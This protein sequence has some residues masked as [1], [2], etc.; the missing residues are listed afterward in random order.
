MPLFLS[1]LPLY[2]RSPSYPHDRRTPEARWQ[3]D[4]VL[5]ARAVILTIILQ[6]SY[7][8]WFVISL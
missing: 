6:V 5:G 1:L 7:R 3:S 2:P 8:T 4:R